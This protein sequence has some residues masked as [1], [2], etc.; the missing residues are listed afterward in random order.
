V[1]TPSGQGCYPGD[2][3]TPALIDARYAQIRS[4][5]ET[6]ERAREL[7]AHTRARLAGQAR[8]TARVETRTGRSLGRLTRGN[9][10][11]ERSGLLAVTRCGHWWVYPVHADR[12]Q[13][14]EIARF[15][16]GIA[17]SFCLAAWSDATQAR[18]C[19]TAWRV[20]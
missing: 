8:V 5:H 15:N 14:D 20:N 18:A 10:P 13:M 19:G 12:E 17:C 7:L 9:E 16:L 11:L 1:S 4:S 6:A 2:V 3:M